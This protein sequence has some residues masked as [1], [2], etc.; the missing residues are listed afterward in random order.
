MRVASR[1]S[2]EDSWGAWI[3]TIKWKT[4]FSNE[5]EFSVK[6]LPSGVDLVGNFTI[7]ATPDN[8]GK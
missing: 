4:Y 1:S 5:L 6:A 8:K 2:R 3:P 7:K